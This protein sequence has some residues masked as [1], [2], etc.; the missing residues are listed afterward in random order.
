[1]VLSA[2]LH[3]NALLGCAGVVLLRVGVTRTSFRSYANSTA[4]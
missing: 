2:S 1:L 4:S 3:S